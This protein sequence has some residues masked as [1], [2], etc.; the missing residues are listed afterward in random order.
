V[1]HLR[2]FGSGPEAI[3][4]HGFS[5]TG[6]QFSPAGALLGRTIIAPDL[7]GHGLSDS[8]ATDI[9][10]VLASLETLLTSPGAPRPLIGY[11]QGARLALLT[12]VEDPSEISSLV[13]VSGTA[14]IRDPIA[15]STRA[16][17]DLELAERIVAIG[18]DPFIDSWTTGGITSVSHLS[19]KHREWDRSVRSE[20]SAVGLASALR[21]YGQGSQPSAW[22]EIRA[23]RLPVLLVTGARDVRYTSI[24]QEMAK[25]IPD[26]EFIVIDGAGHNPF[27]DQPEATYGA[28]S[29]F[30]DRNSGT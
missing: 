8:G 22:E 13:L 16:S 17:E 25:S 26:V 10:S 9:D 27:A 20:N 12:A 15:R 23:L 4:L 21:G 14:G 19:E 5:L 7:P 1:L 11:S 18:L 3:A 24:N 29:A 2:R 30:L 28:V 6:E